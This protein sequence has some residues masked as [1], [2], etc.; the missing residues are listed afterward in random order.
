MAYL[1]IISSSHSIVALKAL[2][3]NN[4]DFKKIIIKDTPATNCKSLAIVEIT[5][6]KLRKIKAKLELHQLDY[7]FSLSPLK[8]PEL[9]VFDMDS[10]LI[11]IEVI[12][13]LA[14]Y[15]N[16]KQEVSLITELAMQGELDFN[17]SLRQRVKHLAGLPQS[18]IQD[19]AAKLE[20]NPGVK[21]FC[22]YL[23]SQKCQLAIASGG[24]TPFAESLKQ[25]VEFSYIRANRLQIDDK[26]LTGEV[27]GTIINAQEKAKAINE[28]R[29][30]LNLTSEQTMAIGDGANDLLMLQAAGIGIAYDAKPAVNQSAS[31]VLKYSSMAVL[32]D[33]FEFTRSL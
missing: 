13:E 23:T 21:E 11:P 31:S 18:V 20:F 29:S 9:V 8:L 1:Y 19:L 30:E 27:E 7:I 26:E 33:L 25:Q 32:I 4:F 14:N 3:D 24:F 15:A 2:L 16:K 10:T 22:Q 12:D 6:Q 17:Q 28:W 5:Q